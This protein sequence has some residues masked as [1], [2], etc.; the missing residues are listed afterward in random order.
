MRISELSSDVGSAE[1]RRTARRR[2]LRRHI[3]GS[4]NYLG[5]PA[6]DM[7]IDIFIQHCAER[8]IATG[9]LCVSSA[10][11]LST[12]LRLVQR[13]CD[14]GLIRQIADTTAVSSQFLV[15]TPNLAWRLLASF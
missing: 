12:A 1:R 7:L 13:M 2:L 14:D 3:V 9:D 4:R 5:E 8:K 6:W 15:F 10:L 11:P